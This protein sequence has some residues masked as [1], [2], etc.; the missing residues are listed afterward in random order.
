M[1]AAAQA[2]G[3]A[4]LG[5]LPLAALGLAAAAAT[6]RLTRDTRLRERAW[7]L[8]LHLPLMGALLAALAASRPAAVVRAPEPVAMAEIAATFE[9]AEVAPAAAPWSVDLTALSSWALGAALLG[10]VVRLLTALAGAGRAARL[11]RRARPFLDARVQRQAAQGAARLGVSAPDIR[12]SADVGAPILAGVRRPVVL[13]PEVLVQAASPEALAL[14]CIHELAHRRRRDNL[15][16]LVEEAVLGGLWFN[17][18]AYPLRAGLRAVRE[19]ACDA[20]ALAAEPR[21]VRRLYAETLVR[22]LRLHA[23]P[24]LQP[25]FIGAQ[26]RTAMRLN[27]LLHPV[28]PPRAGRRFAAAGLIGGLV[29]ATGT[30]ALA[31]G[32]AQGDTA[33][34]RKSVH[35]YTS[36][37]THDE[38]EGATSVAGTVLSDRFEDQGEGRSAAA[39]RVEV[40]ASGVPSGVIEVDGRSQPAGYDPQGLKGRIARV[41]TRNPDREGRPVF[42]LVT[43]RAAL[44]QITPPARI[45]EARGGEPGA[46]DPAAAPAGRLAATL[47]SRPRWVSRPTGEDLAAAYPVGAK[48][49]GTP[50]RATVE[51]SVSAQGAMNGCTVL[52]ESPAGAGFGRATLSV[53]GKFRM[54]ATDE[55]GRSVGGGSVRIPMM[56]RLGDAADRMPTPPLVSYKLTPRPSLPAT[57]PGQGGALTVFA[58]RFI[59]QSPELGRYEGDV[60]LR[61]TTP[62]DTQVL[63]DGRPA[64]VDFDLGSLGAVASVEIEFR[65]APNGGRQLSAMRI[66]TGR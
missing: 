31:T 52:S 40:Q 48:A 10:A 23:G 44:Q 4:L 20:L 24:E 5:G 47:I 54:A 62:R 8:A 57:K 65:P 34:A 17:P 21:A 49:S 19:E 22:S 63:L 55:D 3:L 32:L 26:R 60:T 45:E 42:N 66:T 13:L 7:S 6:E 33:D 58:E 15:R 59:D 30:A 16:L 14:I 12:V 43:G 27:A 61:G 36:V 51:C 46:P 39:G 35:S 9:W 38:P 2:G 25:A 18:A 37:T 64:P 11:A 29:I 28:A 1:N 56:W 41:E 53:A 50:G